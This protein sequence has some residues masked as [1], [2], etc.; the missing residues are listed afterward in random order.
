[1]IPY[2][3]LVVANY[4]EPYL[5]LDNKQDYYLGVIVPDIRYYCGIPRKKTHLSVKVIA[6]FF[7]KYPH[8]RSFILGYLVHCLTDEYKK[9]TNILPLYIRPVFYCLPDHVLQVLIELY[10]IENTRLYMQISSTS[11]E[12]LRNNLNIKDNDVTFFIQKINALIK[13][14]SIESEINVAQNLKILK[15][16][17]SGKYIKIA[18]MVNKSTIKRKLFAHFNEDRFRQKIMSYILSELRKINRFICVDRILTNKSS[19]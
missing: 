12:L 5:Y 9:L 18:N 17:D 4:L 10:Y 6:R 19:S 3:H 1:M 13:T 11:N 16:P 7:K 15:H 2:S 8:L 14:P